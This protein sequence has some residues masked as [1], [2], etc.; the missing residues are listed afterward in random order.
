VDVPECHDQI[1]DSLGSNAG[2]IGSGD[3]DFDRAIGLGRRNE[4]LLERLVAALRVAAFVVRVEASGDVASA[5]AVDERGQD[6]RVPTRAT[7]RDLHDRHA[8]RQS[9]ELEGFRWM[10]RAVASAVGLAAPGPRDRVA[11]RELV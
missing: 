2:R 5:R 7:R 4:G 9:K 1:G 11:D 8:R 10:A 6:L 3:R